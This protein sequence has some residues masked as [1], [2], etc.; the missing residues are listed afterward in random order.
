[1][2]Q[3]TKSKTFNT[4]ANILAPLGVSYCCWYVKSGYCYKSKLNR[5]CSECKENFDSLEQNTI[6]KSN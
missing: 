2:N 6:P 3:Q 4:A 5:M 1:M